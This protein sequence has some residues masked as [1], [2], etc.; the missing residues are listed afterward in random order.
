MAFHHAIIDWGKRILTDPGREATKWRLGLRWF[1]DLTKHCYHELNEDRAFQMAAALTYRTIFGLIPLFVMALLVFNAFGGFNEIG[2]ELQGKITAYI[3][4]NFQL[5]TESTNPASPTA[6]PSSSGPTPTPAATPTDAANSA[7]ATA[8][9]TQ[10]QQEIKQ[11]VDKMF[12]DLTT[13]VQGVSFKSIGAV[14]LVMLIWAALSLVITVEQC[15]NRIYNA[16][17]GRS[18]H[19][20]IAIYW[21]V[22]TLGPV[23]LMVSLWI[24]GQLVTWVDN[25]A[26]A[27]EAGVRSM[28]AGPVQWVLALL[29]RFAA[30][31]A[32]WLLLF[33]LY[34]LMPSTR[35]K[36]RA[37]V[38]GA[39]IAA[40]LWEGAKAGFKLYVT[41]AVATSALYGSL[42]LI[43]LFLLWLYLT[44]VIVLIGLELTYTLQMMP[45][46]RFKS[47]RYD[48]ANLLIDP[49]WV[50]PV[51]AGVAQAFNQGRTA[52]VTD[53]ARTLKLP[54]RA[55]DRLTETLFN[56]ELLRRVTAESGGESGYTLALPPEKVPLRRLLDLA[57]DLDPG[58]KSEQAP[59]GA[60]MRR[61]RDLQR[62]QAGDATLASLISCESP[63]A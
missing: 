27:E 54:I 24:T 9:P 62:E 17:S 63:S 48:E 16:P 1:A 55:I 8:P 15:F 25:L 5:P 21:A 58:A 2:G 4:A 14:G 12:A 10:N 51:M 35:V 13:R 3:G 30:L 7:A 46:G 28:L 44:W 61:L 60:W 6:D 42:G 37:A 45:H 32:S 56:A 41:K 34:L 18:W 57:H 29:S 43:P 39:L 26:K 20:R 49:R 23:L 22:I 52:M 47:Q 59:A 33:L 19:L 11:S 53:L 50:V 40:L 31:F 38:I 36:V